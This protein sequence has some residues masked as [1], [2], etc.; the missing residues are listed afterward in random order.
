MR[1]LY[2]RSHRLVFTLAMRICAR[3][4]LAEEVTLDV[5]SD[6]WRR[7][8]DY[9]ATGGTVLGWMMMLARSRSID[10]V[11]FEQRQKRTAIPREAEDA[12]ASEPPDP[13]DAAGMRAALGCALAALTA[14]E[15]HTI[16]TA[17]FGELTYA[18]TAVRL[19][20]PIG[21]VKTR[22]RSALSKLRELL[23]SEKEGA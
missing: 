3:R 10:R 21:T 14:D 1:A 6:V 16:E 12:P 2:E 19:D 20:Q 8:S 9:D 15:R 22:I 23:A 11:R 18:E 17:F 5:F 13:I 7:S 4:E